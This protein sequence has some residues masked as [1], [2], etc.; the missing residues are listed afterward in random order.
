MWSDAP[1]LI[2]K[3]SPA[4]KLIHWNPWSCVQVSLG[5]SAVWV[6]W[7]KI[8]HA[9]YM[10]QLKIQ[11]RAEWVPKQQYCSQ[12]IPQCTQ[13]IS[14]W[15]ST[16]ALWKSMQLLGQQHLIMLPVPQFPWFAVFLCLGLLKTQ[17]FSFSVHYHWL[18]LSF[19]SGTFFAISLQM[20]LPGKL[21]A[22]VSISGSQPSF[23]SHVFTCSIL[24]SY[25]LAVS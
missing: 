11:A 21:A 10:I 5:S 20:P 4:P 7:C 24:S 3:G 17:T 22:T 13:T 25:L 19:L 1:L 18:T 16:A 6:Q 14:F 8:A 9:S 15:V 23:Q 2:F 12:S